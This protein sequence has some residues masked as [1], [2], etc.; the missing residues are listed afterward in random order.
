LFGYQWHDEIGGPALVRL[1][2]GDAELNLRCAYSTTSPR[3]EIVRR[4]PG[5]LWEP[6]RGPERP[7]AN[8]VIVTT[9]GTG[10]RSCD[11]DG[12]R[13]GRRSE[14]AVVADGHAGPRRARRNHRLRKT[15]CGRENA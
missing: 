4:I 10:R 5:T 1:P 13:D 12:V 3:L 6:A 2:A 15:I 7:R 14:A 11:S 9:M 8:P